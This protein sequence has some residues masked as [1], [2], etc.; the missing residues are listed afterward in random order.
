MNRI[1]QEQRRRNA[2]AQDCWQLYASHRQRVT[3]LLLE[4]A[5][6]G[7]GRLCVLGAGNCNDLDLQRLANA[8]REIHLVDVDRQA[9]VQGVAA[10]SVQDEQ[11]VRLHGDVDLTGITDRLARWSP[12]A[13]PEP[14]A[15]D[16]LLAA[17]PSAVAFAL[18]SAQDVVASVCL[19]SQLIEAVN[20]SLGEQH[21]RFLDVLTAVRY[22]HARLMVRLARPGGRL[23]LISDFVSSDSCPELATVP[24]SQLPELAARLINARN[25][26][27]GLNP[28]VL[29]ALFCADPWLEARVE[30]VRLSPPWTWRFPT[31]VYAV[32]AIEARR[33]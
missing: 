17:I 23:L 32:C 6:S 11:S 22:Q 13:P 18:P 12:E 19:L 7:T 31:R 27:T 24:E 33:R 16:D 1:T 21:P 3:D 14:A 5:A 25:F 20:V 29:R 26:F 28:A 9:L 2:A 8:Y 4:K 15:V 30:A 10:Q